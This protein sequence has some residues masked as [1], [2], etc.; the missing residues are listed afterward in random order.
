MPSLI[1]GRIVEKE[2][3]LPIQDAS[4]MLFG[5]A[6]PRIK[7]TN[8]EGWF[9]I[10]KG[11]MQRGIYIVAVMKSGYRMKTQTVRYSGSPVSLLVELSAR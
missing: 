4:V 5:L 2:T 9:N 1:Y 6:L 8:E 10:S 11:L 7:T 3:G